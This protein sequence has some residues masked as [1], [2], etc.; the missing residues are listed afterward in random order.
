MRVLLVSDSPFSTSA[1]GAL[2]LELSTR[3][4]DEGHEVTILG[5]NY[6]GHPQSIDGLQ[7]V[8]G[9]GPQDLYGQ[10][11]MD[12]CAQQ[13]GADVIM[14]LKD[15]YVFDA[16]RLQRLGTPWVPVVC[17]DT[18]PLNLA[19]RE[20]LRHAAQVFTPTQVGQQMLADELVT[21]HYTPFGVD[22]SFWT[23]GDKA[24]A[25]VALGLDTESFVAAFVGSNQTRPS[26]KGLE[27]LVLSW[28]LFLQR[29]EEYRDSILYLHTSMD[30]WRGGVNLDVMLHSVGVPAVNYRHP[31]RIEYETGSLPRERLRDLYRAADVLI[32]P[33]TGEG[34]WMPGL[35][36]MACGCP[37]IG[38][39]FAGQRETARVGWRIPV[40]DD[41]GQTLWS[42]LGAFRFLP[43]RQAILAALVQAYQNRDDAELQANARMAAVRYEWGTVFD[44][45]WAPAL[46]A[47]E[48]L[49]KEACLV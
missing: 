17:I 40:N 7:V 44:T 23:P 48:G 24:T 16:N 18:E 39:D 49:I 1:Y 21:S 22:T 43:K 25:R 11:I 14:T 33:S 2:G 32:G 26:R 42:P 46:Q 31:D 3:M 37:T 6:Y 13:V 15:P 36:A 27:Q 4:R 38:C 12:A 10:T 45:H 20:Q 5:S 19:V 35:E 9:V 41:T 29:A 28:W 30:G 47:T 8:G 34:F